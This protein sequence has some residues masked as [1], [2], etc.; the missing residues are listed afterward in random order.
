VGEASTHYLFSQDAVPGILDYN[1][2]ARLIVCIRNP[3]EMAPSFH[4]ENVWQG[5]ET[6]RDFEKAW[7][8]QGSRRQGKHIPG[9]VRKDPDRLQYGA[10]CSLGEQVQ[11]LFT[12]ARREQ[13]LLL[14]LD[15]I[16][17]DPQREYEKTLHF[18]GID[19][20]SYHPEFTVYN[21]RK[22]A[23]STFVSYAVRRLSQMRRDLGFRKPVNLYGRIQSSVNWAKPEKYDLSPALRNELRQ[24]FEPDIHLLEDLLGRDF[25]HWLEA[26]S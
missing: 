7:R 5:E 13:V 14:V 9:T 11:R 25:S 20:N 21:S 2:D 3:I 12:H 15:D 17:Q 24:Y 22:G 6:V 4:A 1:A 23:R 26:A 18:L 10:Y 8:L 19:P 16:A